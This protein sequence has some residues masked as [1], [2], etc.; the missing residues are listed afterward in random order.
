MGQRYSG[1]VSGSLLFLTEV[2][3]V[4]LLFFLLVFLLTQVSRDKLKIDGMS[5]PARHTADADAKKHHQSLRDYACVEDV[6]TKRMP[7]KFSY[8]KGKGGKASRRGG[9]TATTSQ[10]IACESNLEVVRRNS[11]AC[12][13][14][15]KLVK[16]ECEM[17]TVELLKIQN[18]YDEISDLVHLELLPQLHHHRTAQKL[19]DGVQQGGGD[20]ADSVEAL[21]R[22]LELL[23][24][25]LSTCPSC[26]SCA[27]ALTTEPRQDGRCGPHFGNARCTHDYPW[28]NCHESSGW[29]G[30][31]AEHRDAQDDARFDYMPATT[32]TSGIVTDWEFAHGTHGTLGTRV[33][34]AAHVGKESKEDEETWTETLTTILLFAV[35]VLSFVFLS[36]HHT[37][38][39]PDAQS[40]HSPAPEQMREGEEDELEPNACTSAARPWETQGINA[41]EMSATMKAAVEGGG[42]RAVVDPTDV[43]TVK[44]DVLSFVSETLKRE[45]Q[46]QGMKMAELEQELKR[47][48][49]ILQ[50]TE[51]ASVTSQDAQKEYASFS[52][53]QEQG[54]G[55]RHRAK[56]AANARSGFSPMSSSQENAS[57]GGAATPTAAASPRSHAAPSSPTRLLPAAAG[58]ILSPMSN[59][60]APPFSPWSPVEMVL[61]SFGDMSDDNELTFEQGVL[62]R[63][64]LVQHCVCL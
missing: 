18:M 56:V 31:T 49:G 58:C 19:R 6:D 12:Q 53:F 45:K 9:D 30:N 37:Q 25:Q 23:R 22:E 29:C 10:C 2:L 39:S 57:T 11:S 38:S 32:N 60:Q 40:L 59:S 50:E 48:E 42:S 44:N 8:P 14:Q 1:S 27:S 47:E 62:A 41:A 35:I 7:A 63:H 21:R 24:S 64:L 36:H 43:Q 3:L 16:K 26:P 61:S 51:K 52:S 34:K 13:G 17:T 20:V 55:I 33:R 28:C 54:S 4:F 5:P 46:E 15:L